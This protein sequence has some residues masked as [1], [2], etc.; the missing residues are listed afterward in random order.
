MKNIIPKTACLAVLGSA[1]LLATGCKTIIRE[2]VISTIET[3]FGA[4]ITENKQTQVPEIKVGY[5]RSQ[6]YSVPTGK[7]VENSSTNNAMVTGTNGAVANA[8]ISNAA[9]VTP[10]MVAGIRVESGWDIGL[11]T[12]NISENFALGDIAVTSPAAIAMYIASAKDPAT[13]RAASDAMQGK[14]SAQAIA[15]HLGDLTTQTNLAA[16]NSLKVKPLTSAQKAN[17]KEFKKGDFASDYADA[18][19]EEKN[20]AIGN[21][22]SRPSRARDF[23]EIIR[24]M[25]DATKTQ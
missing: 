21:I 15:K 9:N 13:A 23:Q 11:F 22:M 19:A 12:A 5:I 4:S 20:D 1:T 7:M 2:N 6:F 17:G 18:L 16:F 3:G 10:N 24:K 25:E 8:Q 14:D